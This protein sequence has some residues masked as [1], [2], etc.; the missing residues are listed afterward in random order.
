MSA[1]P[2]SSR[3]RQ[4]RAL[5]LAVL[6]AVFGALAPTLSHALAWAGASPMQ[7]VCSSSASPGM[8]LLATDTPDGQK[9]AADLNDCPFCLLTQ[10]RATPPQPWVDRFGVPGEY[11]A[12]V[13]GQAF[14]FVKPAALTPPPRGPPR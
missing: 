13:T 11:A 10:D 7:A 6:L 3:L 4:P 9:V 1:I 2:L 5:W 8:T 12:P 14:F